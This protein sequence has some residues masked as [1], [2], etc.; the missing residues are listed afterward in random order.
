[1]DGN[2]DVSVK[3]NDGELDS[4]IKSVTITVEE[5][6][7]PPPDED[8]IINEFELNPDGTDSGN[9]WV[10]LFNPSDNSIDLS[11]WS[12]KNN[13]DDIHTLSGS[14]NADSY[15]V[16]TFHSQWIDNSDER[17]ILISPGSNV[18]DT[19]PIKA[20]SSNDDSSWQRVPRHIPL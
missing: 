17:V 12:L 2:Y 18:K 5:P 9:E 11:G 6:I 15:L 13:D 7:K 20:D 4:N 16:I 14:I 8:L 1:V 3:V 10:E 19:T